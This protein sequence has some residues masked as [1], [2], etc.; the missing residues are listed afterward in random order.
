M[1]SRKVRGKKGRKPGKK[2]SSI[3]VIAGSKK[4]PASK[5]EVAGHTSPGAWYYCWRCWR[6]C[7][8]YRGYDAY[9]CP[10]CGA[11]NLT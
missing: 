9:Y 4:A 3:D 1:T 11:L 7:W 6:W 5:G 2:L 10:F 8:V